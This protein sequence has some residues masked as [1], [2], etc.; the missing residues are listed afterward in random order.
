MQPAGAAPLWLCVNVP[1]RMFRAADAVERVRAVLLDTALPPGCLHLELTE[2][3]CMTNGEDARAALRELRELGI[4]INMD[5]FGTGYSSLSYL[6]RFSYDTLK[7]DRSCIQAMDAEERAAEIRTIV[8]VARLLDM[9]VVA[10]GVESRGQ[11]DALMALGCT[12]G[13]GYLFSRPLAAPDA[14]GLLRL[15]AVG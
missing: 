2:R 10:E 7:I 4:R 12:A 1:A 6:Q 8:G 3:D 15:H 5:D 13:Q 14:T 11:A 9:D